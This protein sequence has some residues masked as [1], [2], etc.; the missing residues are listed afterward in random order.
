[1]PIKSTLTGTG[2]IIGGYAIKCLAYNAATYQLTLDPGES[3]S[4]EGT[5]M[6]K[7]TAGALAVI[8]QLTEDSSLSDSEDVWG[9]YKTA[10]IASVDSAN[11]KITFTQDIGLDTSSQL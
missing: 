10:E 5:D 11:Y 4:N 7:F 2:N 1:M 3:D 8:N 6:S 9:S